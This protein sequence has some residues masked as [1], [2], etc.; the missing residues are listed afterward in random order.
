MN[1]VSDRTSVG[2]LRLRGGGIF[3]VGGMG[4]MSDNRPL[5]ELFEEIANQWVDAKAAADLLED[6]KSAYF[7]EQM[8]LYPDMA[9]SRAEILVKSSEE[10]KNYVEK[11]VAARK[12]A[13]LYW[14]KVETLK[15]RASEWQSQEANQRIQARL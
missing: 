10:W 12:R 9:V 8:Q 6:C 4:D 5:S 15:M 13:N 3:T 11:T 7:S 2:G 14:V 1:T